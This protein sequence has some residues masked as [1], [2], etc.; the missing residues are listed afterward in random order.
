MI[1]F[2]TFDLK[3]KQSHQDQMNLL[4][5]DGSY[6]EGGGQILRS[7]L[8]LST[9]TQK[10]IQ[11]ENIR[12]NRNN[13]GLMPSHLSTIK[14]LG[15][16]CNAKIEGLSIGSTNIVFTPG[17]L[18]DSKLKE[19]IGT[20]G[21]IPLLLQAIIPTVA[22]S[23]KKLE[24]SI[25]GGTDVPWSPTTNY[26]KFVLN[27]AYSRLGIKFDLDVKKRGYYPKGGGQID[28]TVYPCKKILSVYLTKRSSNNANII[29][30]F[31]GIDKD[32][33]TNHVNSA[34]DRL[35]KNGFSTHIKLSEDAALNPG[36]SFLVH[37]SDSN[38]INGADELYNFTNRFDFTKKATNSFT[39]LSMGV[40]SNLA[41]MIVTPLS[42][43]KELSIF[44]VN[45]IS[46]HL[47]TNL[48]ITSEITG[49]KSGI[50]KINDGYEIRIIGSD[51]G[52]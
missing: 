21:S 42:L 28:V 45:E 25:V 9:I 18:Q 5:I 40:D 39:K 41:D 47:Q 48:H 29:C 36:A 50:S 2:L 51:T 1:F 20:A 12:H 4:T 32:E 27:E 35:E 6:G 13:P 44:T 16:I 3:T 8:T 26:T 33:I 7:A 22:L 34:K 52:I 17:Q 24:L 37:D 31:S 15:K 11:I 49:C 14:L 43:S 10:P 19:N 23:G 30:S 38:S 46:K